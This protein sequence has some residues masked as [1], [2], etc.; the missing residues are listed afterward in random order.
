MHEIAIIGAGTMGR[1]IAYEAALGGYQTILED[2]SPQI[3]ER[4]QAWITQSFDEGVARGK[5]ASPRS[6]PASA[7]RWM[8]RPVPWKFSAA[9]NALEREHDECGG[10][11]Q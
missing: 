6:R 3:L 4:A 8:G 9:D 11:G 5:V 1:G 2:V 7:L 10:N